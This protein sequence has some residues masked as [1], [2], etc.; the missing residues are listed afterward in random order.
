[1]PQFGAGGEAPADRKDASSARRR[2]WKIAIPRRLVERIR[3][4]ACRAV[5]GRSPAQWDARTVSCRAMPE[6]SFVLPCLDEAETLAACLGEIQECIDAHGLD[7]EILVADNGSRDGSQEIARRGGAR[8]VDVA[9][10]GYGNALMGGFDAA[11]GD[12]LIMGDADQSYDF[13]EAFPMIEA[14]RGGAEL[15]MGSRFRGEIRPGAMPWSHRWIGNP[16]LSWVGRTLFASG[17]S[18]FHCGLRGLTKKAYQAL[19]LRTSGM[20]F[21]TEVVVK[22]ASRGMRIAEVPVTL[23]PDGRSRAPHLR[24]WRDGWRHLRFMMTLSPRFTLGLPGLVL[25]LIGAFGIALL[26]GGPVRIGG[27]AFDI[28]SLLVAS[29]LVV[30]GYQAMT[31]AVAARLFAVEEELGPPAPWARRAFEVF[32][33]ERGILA[34]FV[35]TV[36]GLLPIGALAWRWVQQGFPDLEP[37]VTLRPVIVGVTLVALGFQTLLMS[38]VYSMLG[39]KRRR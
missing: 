21:A 38:F 10:R 26:F 25:A 37:A 4:A 2:R 23:R 34:G 16:I 36:L 31:T 24:R 30:V 22:A 15:V 1:M 19:G 13:R 29:L 17:V 35:L 18:D 8:V 11:R 39:I 32:T 12:Y 28:H 6:I 33:L 27:A 14:M 3:I 5:L 9:E 7:A 20:E